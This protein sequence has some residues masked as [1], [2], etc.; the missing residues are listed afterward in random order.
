MVRAQPSTAMSWVAAKKFKGRKMH[1]SRKT[2]GG[3]SEIAQLVTSIF[4]GRLTASRPIL[5]AHYFLNMVGDE[6]QEQADQILT[7]DL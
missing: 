2:L 3:V 5:G 7:G 6:K 1:I 4:G